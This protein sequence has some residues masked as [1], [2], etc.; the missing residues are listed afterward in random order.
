MARARAEI[1]EDDL[2]ALGVVRQLLPLRRKLLDDERLEHGN[3]RVHLFDTLVLLAA[4]FY[5]PTVRSLRLIEQLSQLDWVKDRTGLA[6][7]PRTTLSDAMRRLDPERLRPVI[8]ELVSR[9]PHLRH[10]DPDL[11]KLTRDLLVADASYFNLVGEVAWALAG[12]KRNGVPQPRVRLNLQLEVSNFAPADLDVSGAGDGSEP[13]AFMRRLKGGVVYVV[14]RNFVHFGFID[15]VFD[16]GSNLVLRLK[17]DTRFTVTE[18]RTLTQRDREAGVLA[19]EVGFLGAPETPD[20]NRHKG[21]RSRTTPP[22]TRP[23]RRV[24]LW[25]EKNQEEVYLLTDLLDEKDVP[26]YVVGAIYRKRWQVEL[27]FRWLK[28]WAA[29]DHALSFSKE[30]IT[31]QFYVAVVAGL[32]M[33]LR[34]GRKVNKYM[35]FLMGQVAGG[36]ATYARIEPMLERVE[37]EKRLERER[38]ARKKAAEGVAKAAKNMA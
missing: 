18:A 26:A 36:L 34:S 3:T 19:D 29:W 5:N 35:L 31:L 9:L 13:A 27:F 2:L 15:A 38:L 4:A 14:D 1:A 30:G 22:P 28:L 11:E 7:V 12:T 25:D 24:T 37:H 33:H 6:R 17:K 32:L 21:R 16:K 20:N 8:E 23:L 10:Q